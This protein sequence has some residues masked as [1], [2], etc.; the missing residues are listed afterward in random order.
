MKEVYYLLPAEQV[1]PWL[2]IYISI[3]FI[4]FIIWVFCFFKALNQW[5]DFYAG[6]GS[7][8]AIAVS[9]ITFS[10]LNVKSASLLLYAAIIYTIVITYG[11]VGLRFYVA[12]VACWSGVIAGALLSWYLHGQLAFSLI[13][14]YIFCSFLG[15]AMSYI[16]DRQH[17]EN[18]LQSC[19]LELQHTEMANQAQ[20]LEILSR[21]DGLTGVTNRRH[22]EQLLHDEWFRAMRHQQPV[23]VLMIDIDH[24]KAYNDTLG[25]I[26]GDHCLIKIAQTLSSIANRSGEV[27]ARYGGE[28][29]LVLLPMTDEGQALWQANRL[30][31]SINALQINYPEGIP[32]AQVT[33][34]IGVA[35]HIPRLNEDVKDLVN[36]ADQALYEAKSSGRNCFMCAEIPEQMQ[37]HLKIC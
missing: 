20:Q 19:L 2:K 33:V 37:K 18:Y 28:E 23:S 8:V 32:H 11:Y 16:T 31:N 27:V 1:L 12:M 29:F 36:Y 3:G 14:T 9:I 22:L 26:A 24:F 34:S 7:A 15:M 17:R 5:F 10:T 25:H 13:N 4:I 30:I 6:C 35:S 21:Q